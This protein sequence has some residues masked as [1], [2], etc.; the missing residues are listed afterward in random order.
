MDE[1]LEPLFDEDAIR[2]KMQELADR[3]SRDYAGSDL[4]IVCVL[5]A[6]AFF[7]A[8]LARSLAVPSR[9]AFVCASSYGASTSA[10]TEVEIRKDIEIDISGKHVLLVDTIADSGRTLAA[11]TARYAQ[12]GPA[13]IRSAVLLDKRSRR[14]ADLRLN[15]VGFEIPDLFVVGYGMDFAEKYRNLPYIAVLPSSDTEGEGN[16]PG[17]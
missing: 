15:Y 16:R 1:E 14:T 5:K 3:I 10:V 9:I 13:S 2:N 11:L 8:D 4:V 12:R 6:A 17:T 7:A